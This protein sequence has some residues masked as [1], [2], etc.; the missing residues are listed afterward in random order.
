MRSRKLLI[1]LNISTLQNQYSWVQIPFGA[2]TI[3]SSGDISKIVEIHWNSPYVRLSSIHRGTPTLKCTRDS[4]KQG[5]LRWVKRA[6][7][8]AWRFHTFRQS[9]EIWLDSLGT[10][11]GVMKE[12]LRHANISAT[13]NV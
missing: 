6:K 8:F 13:M 3:N 12:L 4:F 1:M 11:L 9:H 5:Y 2:P 10:P 7:G